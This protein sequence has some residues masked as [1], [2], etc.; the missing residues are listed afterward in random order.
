MVLTILVENQNQYIGHNLDGSVDA[1]MDLYAFACTQGRR[2]SYMLVEI[3]ILTDAMLSSVHGHGCAS[4]AAARTSKC[5][6]A[7]A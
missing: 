5:T 7:E 6:A 1:C 3:P 2:A 4:A